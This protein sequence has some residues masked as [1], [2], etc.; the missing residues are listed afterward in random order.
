MSNMST[1]Y[2][3]DF[4][5]WV[6]EQIECFKRKDFSHIDIEHL[7]EEMT[8]LGNSNPQ[9]MESHMVIILIHMLKQKFQPGYTSKSWQDSIDNARVQI[10]QLKEN[11][12][13]L[14]NHLNDK[15]EKCF[16]KAR[17]YAAKQTRIDLRSFP[18]EC[19]W[20][21]NEILGE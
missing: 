12:P 21:L 3:T 5:K 15:V 1:L 17:R 13:S 18:K 4:S 16:T 9:A 19:P 10:D 2:E 14:K 6:N 7:I 20:T 8:E 11:N